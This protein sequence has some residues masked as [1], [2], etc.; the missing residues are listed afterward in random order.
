MFICLFIFHFGA[1]CTVGVKITEKESIRDFNSVIRFG[2]E[3][4]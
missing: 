3:I 4:S 1:I 2:A